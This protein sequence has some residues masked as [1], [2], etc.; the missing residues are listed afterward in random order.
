[1]VDIQ[2]EHAYQMQSTIFQNKKHVLLGETGK[3]KLPRYCKNLGLGFKTPKEAIVGSYIRQE[4][5][6]HW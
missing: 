4:M 2:T 3:E 6:L 1:M 5:P